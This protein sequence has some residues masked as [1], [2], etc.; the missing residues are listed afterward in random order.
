[1]GNQSSKS[2]SSS[3]KKNKLSRR[4]SIATVTSFQG[5]S[6]STSHGNYDWI[7]ENQYTH[8]S[9]GTLNAALN[10]AIARTDQQHQHQHQ[11]SSSTISSPPALVNSRRKS[12]TE[13]FARRKQ[14]L[15]TFQP[16]ETD[17]K[18]RELYQR[19]VSI[20]IFKA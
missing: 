15:S 11:K 10:A 4:K 7:E 18:E 3:K 5:T 8:L 16:I 13:F 19:Q 14:S 1:M 9:E 17:A 6:S 2:S 12:I 20:P